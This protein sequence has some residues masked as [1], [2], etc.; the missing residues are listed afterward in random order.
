MLRELHGAGQESFEELSEEFLEEILKQIPAFV[1]RL[2]NEL[3][4]QGIYDPELLEDLERRLVAE[5]TELLGKPA[6]EQAEPPMCCLRRA[7]VSGLSKY[8]DGVNYRCLKE[9]GLLPTSSVDLAADM[10]GIQV[11]WALA[12]AREL[13]K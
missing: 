3:R 5:L 1:A 6:S 4:R 7:V 11:R 13:A 8:R 12:K 9:K 10:A 2:D